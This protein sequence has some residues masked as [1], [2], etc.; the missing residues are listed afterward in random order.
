[1]QSRTFGESKRI[2]ELYQS[3]YPQARIKSVSGF[4]DVQ[5]CYPYL[6]FEDRISYDMPFS[7]EYPFPDYELFDSFPVFLGN[8]QKGIWSYPIVTSLGCPYQC[9]YCMNRKRAWKTRSVRNCYEELRQAREKWG[10]RSVA[11]LDDCFNLSKER[12]L[13][14]CEQIKPANLRWSCANG[15]RADRFDDDV[16]EATA[17][18]G[19]VHLNFGIESVIPEVLQVMQKGETIEQIERAIDVAREWF[20]SVGGFFIIGLP[21]SSYERDL[22]S[23]KWAIRKRVRFHFSYYVPFDKGMQ[24]DALFYGDGASPLSD[25]YPKELQK[26][27]YDVASAW[28]EEGRGWFWDLLAKTECLW[29]CD[30]RHL[31]NHLAFCTARV[32]ARIARRKAT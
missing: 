32:I 9:I 8:W 13:E 12:V 28:R 14:F 10:I 16:A 24:Y 27:I 29:S 31:L 19:Y 30:R 2:V 22:A 1:V 20:D 7:D 17:A 18:S 3:K 15:L 25:E 5:C 11:I 6:D 23:L 21:G 4:L 26:R